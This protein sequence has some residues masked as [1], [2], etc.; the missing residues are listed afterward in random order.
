[1]RSHVLVEGSPGERS[2]AQRGKERVCTQAHFL[3]VKNGKSD[4]SEGEY[5]T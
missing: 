1:M 2:P 3:V 4:S 5:N